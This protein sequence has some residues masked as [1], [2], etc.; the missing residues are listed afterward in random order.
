MHALRSF[1]WK[2]FLAITSCITLLLY[3]RGRLRGDDSRGKVDE[4]ALQE[5]AR[6][7][8]IAIAAA[9]AQLSRSEAVPDSVAHA[10]LQP[11]KFRNLSRPSTRDPVQINRKIEIAESRKEELLAEIM[12]LTADTFPRMAERFRDYVLLH[13]TYMDLEYFLARECTCDTAAVMEKVESN[14]TAD[15]REPNK[16]CCS[17]NWQLVADKAEHFASLIQLLERRF[18][19]WAH[20]HHVSLSDLYLSFDKSPR[21]RGIVLTAA[22]GL[23]TRMAMVSIKSIRATGCQ[24]PIEVYYVGDSDLDESSRTRIKALGNGYDVVTRDLTQT[25]DP[26]TA[27]LVGWAAKPFAAMFSPFS[28]VLLQDADV[29]WLRTP[30][31]VFEDTVYKT[32]GTLFYFD[33]RAFT[34]SKDKRY[35]FVSSLIAPHLKSLPVPTENFILRRTSNDVQD[36]G[37]VAV[38]KG[39]RENFYGLLATCKLNAFVESLVTY[40]HVHGDKDTFWIGWEMAGFRTYGWTP[41]PMVSMGYLTRGDQSPLQVVY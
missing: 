21:T 24:L 7:R 36:S 34:K 29:V 27:G 12:P 1:A 23:Q 6:Q 25:V 22:K 26:W 2:V 30:N 41:W 9:Q 11:G 20:H 14:M 13:S 37:V 3:F 40:D 17:Q 19:P 35:N 15:H 10:T 32:T 38:D 31:E 8:E 16:H 33:R 39:K 4:N 28:E 18:F 5:A